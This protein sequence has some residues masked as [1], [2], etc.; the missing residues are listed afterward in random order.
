[1]TLLVGVAESV[2]RFQDEKDKD[3]QARACSH[4]CRRIVDTRHHSCVK[5]SHL[6]QPLTLAILRGLL[7]TLRLP[8][9]LVSRHRV[10]LWTQPVSAVMGV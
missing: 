10:D 2:A 5:L 7:H 3:L 6:P 8:R 9:P 1:M 4:C